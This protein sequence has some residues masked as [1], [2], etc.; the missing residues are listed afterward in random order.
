MNLQEYRN[1]DMQNIHAGI[2][3]A[4]LQRGVAEDGRA[5]FIPGLSFGGEAL[6]MI[7]GSDVVNIQP[8]GSAELIF[9]INTVKNERPDLQEELRRTTTFDFQEKI[10]MNVSG[11]IGDRVRLGINYNT[12][13]M[14]EFE[15]QTNL[16]Y[17]GGEDD[18][19]RRVEAGNVTLPLPGSLITGSQSLF[20]LKTEMQFGNLNVTSVFSQQKGESS[21][22][23]VS[24]GAQTQNFEVYA[25]EY[26]ANRHFFL[27]QYFRDTYE[28]SLRNLPVI[29]G[30]HY[31]QSGGMGDE[32]IK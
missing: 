9:G 29:S 22:I 13:A 32:Q 19:I 11:T 25:D 15:N 31:H 21:V 3:A 8:Q 4:A 10:Q 1:Y 5:E 23:E 6:D 18:I 28:S 7:F 2:L 24:G 14:F 20:G 26:D 17:T 12:E 30:N 16:E 27:S